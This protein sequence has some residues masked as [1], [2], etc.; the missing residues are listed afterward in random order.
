MLENLTFLTFKAYGEIEPKGFDEARK[1]L[2]YSDIKTASLTRKVPDKLFV[3]NTDTV[4]DLTEG[5]AVLYVGLSPE[6]LVPFIFDKT[7]IV[8]SG[9]YYYATPLLQKAT[10]SYS[11]GCGER[12]EIAI[13]PLDMNI[14]VNSTINV[15]RIYTLLYHEKEAGFKSKPEAHDIWE[16]TYV[17][18]GKM[19]NVT[20]EGEELKTVMKQGDIMLFVPDQ[21]HRQY[22]DKDVSVCYATIGFEMNYSDRDYFENRIFKA[23]NEIK[24]LMEKI[25]S[26]KDSGE[27]GSD[28][29]TLCYLKEIIIKLIRRGRTGD[30]KSEPTISVKSENNLISYVMSYVN[31]NICSKISVSGIAAAIPVNA[32]YLST[33]FK[34]STGIAL[35]NYI[36]DR[37][38]ITAK[39]YIRTGNFSIT[40]VSE[41]LAFTNVQYFSKLF[42]K[43]F[44]VTPSEYSW[45]IKK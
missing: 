21:K 32:S 2:E 45:S 35:S 25:I 34:N 41:R 23:D 38:L 24:K 39:E 11:E 8:K 3:S 28:D 43:K 19:Y 26:E 10:I 42:K 15:G 4:M 30:K 7:V 9:V 33:V 16:L 36:S 1:K 22:S 27:I 14:Y 29:L 5:T 37:K 44:G 12:R 20:G 31:A 6:G 17:D 40:E 18:T 13:P